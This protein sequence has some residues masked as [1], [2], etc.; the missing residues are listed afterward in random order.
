MI[1]MGNGSVPGEHVMIDPD[2]ARLSKLAKSVLAMP[3]KR[4]EESKIGR[5]KKGSDAR[6]AL[7][8]KRRMDTFGRPSE[9]MAV[10]DFEK[11]SDGTVIC[12]DPYLLN[13]DGSAVRIAS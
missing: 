9:Q 1:V 8:A 5:G 6:I 3:H 13:I 10:F 7:S 11:L 2:E 12:H 4:R